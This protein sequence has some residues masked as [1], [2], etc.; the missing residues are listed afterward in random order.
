MSGMIVERRDQVLRTFFSKRRFISSMRLRSAASTKGPFLMLRDMIPPYFR[1]R[2][3]NLSVR[4]LLRV[5]F[6]RTPQ[7]VHGWR[8]PDV[9]P[10][11]PPSG[12]SIGG[13]AAR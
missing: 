11:P 1:R 12:G 10:S 6:S 8:P 3:M 4:L 5:F 2:T 7:G 9:F 13:V